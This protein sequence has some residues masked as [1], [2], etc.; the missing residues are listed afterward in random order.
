MESSSSS[1]SSSWT[2]WSPALDVEAEEQTEESL[3]D[4]ALA[5]TED[6]DVALGSE[7][8]SNLRL[9]LFSRENGN[10]LLIE[11]K[12]PTFY[13]V[14][15]LPRAEDLDVVAGPVPRGRDEDPNK[16]KAA[17]VVV[18]EEEIG[19]ADE[20]ESV[21]EL[22]RTEDHLCLELLR[23]EELTLPDQPR[24]PCKSVDQLVHGILLVAR[25]VAEGSHQLRI[26]V[27]VWL[28]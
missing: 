9:Y 2:R 10:G 5:A 25:Q 15:I 1:S 3:A 8:F 22:G 13:Y 14:L 6:D 27:Q 24:L 16:E 26:C 19:R 20:D 7:G 21:E 28:K 4:E 11:R 17:Q 12:T 23:A 18:W